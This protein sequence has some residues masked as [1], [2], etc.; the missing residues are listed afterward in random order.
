MGQCSR[1]TRF[2]E[3]GRGYRVLEYGGLASSERHGRSPATCGLAL[4]YRQPYC[5]HSPRSTSYV[6][7][8]EGT[9]KSFPCGESPQPATYFRP[10]FCRARPLLP[11]DAGGDEPASQ[12]GNAALIGL[13]PVDRVCISRRCAR[14]LV[15]RASATLP[16]RLNPAAPMTRFPF[17]CASVRAMC[18]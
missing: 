10:T 11:F 1:G 14:P 13:T 17:L 4:M 3:A 18:A 12:H 7:P 9:A 2:S 5:L 15:P 6:K 16:P 8:L